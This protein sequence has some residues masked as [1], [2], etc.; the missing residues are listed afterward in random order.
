MQLDTASH[1]L[2]SHL[3]GVTWQGSTYI[4]SLALVSRHT[5]GDWSTS[6][7]M[8]FR[9]F[10][11]QILKGLGCVVLPP[12]CSVVS[13]IQAWFKRNT[14]YHWG[15]CC[16][17]IWFWNVPVCVQPLREMKRTFSREEQMS[18]I[19]GFHHYFWLIFLQVVARPYKVCV[20]KNI[21]VSILHTFAYIR[22]CVQR[23]QSSVTI[24]HILT[25]VLC[26]EEYL[27]PG[28]VSSKLE[29]FKEVWMFLTV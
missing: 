23:D 29:L 17:G 7:R 25:V 19:F 12:P 22:V 4:C 9:G 5:L 26:F 8:F 15:W 2:L 27:L 11:I 13:G 20:Y 6:M 16:C 10:R 14:T 28:K 18:V 1:C 24:K 3:S 21:C